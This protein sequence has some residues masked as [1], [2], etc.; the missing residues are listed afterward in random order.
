[1][2]RFW[3][4]LID[5]LAEKDLIQQEGSVE[6]V[7]KLS[8]EERITKE[9]ILKEKYAKEFAKNGLR[10][11]TIMPQF[12]GGWVLEDEGKTDS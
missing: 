2:N 4:E 8:L 3:D 7:M 12:V 10:N 6:E 11:V 9:G 5:R 1:M